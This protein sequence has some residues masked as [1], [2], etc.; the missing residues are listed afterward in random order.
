MSMDLPQT[1]LQEFIKSTIS[2]HPSQVLLWTLIGIKG[3][4]E[5]AEAIIKNSP[6]SVWN[7]PIRLGREGGTLLHAAGLWERLDIVELLVAHGVD[8][9]IKDEKGRTAEELVNQWFITNECSADS[10][11]DPC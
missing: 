9:T 8:P 6:A 5:D 3:S 10:S 4:T 7:E 2:S 1:H 11:S